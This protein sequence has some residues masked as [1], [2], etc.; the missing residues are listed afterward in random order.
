MDPLNPLAHIQKLVANQRDPENTGQFHAEMA[1]AFD[2]LAAAARLGHLKAMTVV[3]LISEEGA[4]LGDYGCGPGIV[5]AKRSNKNHISQHLRALADTINADNESPAD[6]IRSLL[7]SLLRD[8]GVE[9][10]VT[11]IDMDDLLN[12]AADKP[13]ERGN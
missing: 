8:R 11:R 3:T 2:C 6:G 7:E 1:S 10:H 12:S 5:F 9:V 4:K 13:A